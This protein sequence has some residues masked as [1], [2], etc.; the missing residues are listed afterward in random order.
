MDKGNTTN[1][2]VYAN[3]LVTLIKHWKLVDAQK[4]SNIGSLSKSWLQAD[5]E[6]KITDVKVQTTD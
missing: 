1:Y 5:N 6:F 2:F 3:K 4:K